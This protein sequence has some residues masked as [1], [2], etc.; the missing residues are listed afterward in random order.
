MQTR[1]GERGKFRLLEEASEVPAWKWKN[2]FYKR[3][4]AAPDQIKFWVK[5]YPDDAPWLINGVRLPDRDGFPFAGAPPGASADRTVGDR[6]NW[7]IDEF[8]SP[9]GEEL[10][11]YLESR[12]GEGITAEDW[13]NVVLRKAQPT[14]QMVA[15]VCRERPMFTEW[16]LLGFVT[17]QSVDPT[18]QESI[19]RWKAYRMA[20]RKK[21]LRHLPPPEDPLSSC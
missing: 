7:V 3:Q 11:K 17:P 14:L 2:V 8:A 4:E 16:V 9:R 10:F 19:E 1:F 15:L 21:L 13:R 6:L 12:Y 5:T 20:E 18:N